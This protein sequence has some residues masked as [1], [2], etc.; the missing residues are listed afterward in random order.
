VLDERKAGKLRG[1]A[2]YP[3][4]GPARNFRPEA[5]P[6]LTFIYCPECEVPAEVTDR[7]MLASTSGPVDH[8]V[9]H[10][11]AGHRLRMA[12][13]LLPESTRQHLLMQELEPHVAHVA[14]G[15]IG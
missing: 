1:R 7:V 10:C 11:A 15:P 9:L 12:S 6:V 5:R 2:S 13:D 14:F 4:A 8:V 3:I